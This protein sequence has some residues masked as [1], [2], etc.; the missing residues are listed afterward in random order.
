MR[1]PC[2]FCGPRDVIE[3][4]V[5]GEARQRPVFEAHELDTPAAREAF[6]DYVY[7]RDNPAGLHVEHW[8][9]GIG[10]QSWLLV[11]R[12]TRTHDILEVAYAA[13]EEEP[14]PAVV[15]TME[16]AS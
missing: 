9:H 14:A 2:P 11:T 6:V 10:C 3:F 4:T 8:Y 15:R 1:I 7:L 13:G 5:H 12:D 16:V